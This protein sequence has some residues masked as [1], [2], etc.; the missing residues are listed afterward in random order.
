[1]LNLFIRRYRI[2]LCTVTGGEHGQDAGRV[3]QLSQE[4]R[5]SVGQFI[6]GELE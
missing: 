2:E 6:K 5:I 4:Q 1:M 3:C